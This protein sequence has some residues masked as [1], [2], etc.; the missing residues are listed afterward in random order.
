MIVRAI[1]GDTLDAI[2]W[3]VLGTTVDVVALAL[4]RNPG[5]AATGPE[6]E[7]GTQ[8]DLPDAT[9]GSTS[10]TITLVQLWD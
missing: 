4:G 5:L 2:C 3:R 9:A 7:A 8:I 6:I 10:E 1:E